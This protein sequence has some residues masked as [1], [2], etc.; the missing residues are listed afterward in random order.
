MYVSLK[1]QCMAKGM[2]GM[3]R[4]HE[5]PVSTVG[6]SYGEVP[7]SLPVVYGECGGYGGAYVSLTSERVAFGMRVRGMC[8]SISRPYKSY[9][10][11]DIG[12]T[13]NAGHVYVVLRSQ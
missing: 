3:Q 12:D 5:M 2:Q 4:M 1:F 9:P 13:K 7:P 11:F 8:M 10:G 6:G